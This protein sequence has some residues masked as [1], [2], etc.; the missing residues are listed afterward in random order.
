MSTDIK[1]PVVWIG[2]SLDDLKGFPSE[3]R[4][5]I[6]YALYLAQLGKKHS[7]AKPLKGFAGAGVLEVVENFNTD[8]YRAI[9]TVKLAEVVYVLHVFQKRVGYAELVSAYTTT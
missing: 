9:Y 1:K 5:E 6:G 7:L 8:T 2:S 3:V 4:G